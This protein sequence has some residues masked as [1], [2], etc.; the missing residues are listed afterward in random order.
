MSTSSDHRSEVA[1]S[2]DLQNTRETSLLLVIEPWGTVYDFTPGEVITVYVRGPQTGRLMI[3]VLGD[4]IV[5][6]GW[7]GSEVSIFPEDIEDEAD[8]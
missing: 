2:F 1:Y 3:D 5:V 4:R 6:Y 8:R 7:V